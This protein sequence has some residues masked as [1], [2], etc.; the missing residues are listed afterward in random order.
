MLSHEG[1]GIEKRLGQHRDAAEDVGVGGVNGH[2]AA[3]AEFRGGVDKAVR[4][5]EQKVGGDVDVAATAALGL[6]Y[7]FAASI[8]H[9]EGGVD[10]NVAAAALTT[11]NGGGDAAVISQMQEIAGVDVDVSGIRL[12]GLDA[13][14]AAIENP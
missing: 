4:G 1:S 6:R 3:L 7:N 11:G 10:G 9:H 13:N 8:Q 2:R 14:L 12:A 5:L